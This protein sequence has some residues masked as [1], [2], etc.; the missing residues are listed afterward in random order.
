MLT[1][2]AAPVPEMGVSPLI[3]IGVS[4]AFGVITVFLLRL[5]ARARRMKSRL[6]VD[7]MMGSAAR[8]MEPLE[9]EG[10]VLVEGEI[11]RAV[12]SEPVAEGTA[13]KVVGHEAYLLRVVPAN[14]V[15]LADA[16]G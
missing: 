10:H 16:H 2:V 12:S 4:A 8:A 1:L 7:A 15:H 11:W 9:P 6:G 3:A 13:L 5:A 14:S